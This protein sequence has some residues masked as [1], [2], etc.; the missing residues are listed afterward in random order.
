[1]VVFPS[2][3]YVNPRRVSKESVSVEPEASM[4]FGEVSIFLGRLSELLPYPIL[5]MTFSRKAFKFSTGFP[6]P[7]AGSGTTRRLTPMSV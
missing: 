1:M 5:E 3:A 6:A 4:F 2:S 7:S